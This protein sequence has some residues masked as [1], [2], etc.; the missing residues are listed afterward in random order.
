MTAVFVRKAVIKEV[1]AQ[2]GP[3]ID[4]STGLGGYRTSKRGCVSLDIKVKDTNFRVINAHIKSD[5][6]R[7]RLRDLTKILDSH[8]DVVENN[9]FS[10]F[11]VGAMNFGATTEG[12]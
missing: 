5:N 7:N 9:A 2:A 11:L 6:L 1:R 10:V 8:Q 4:I 3:S 12:V